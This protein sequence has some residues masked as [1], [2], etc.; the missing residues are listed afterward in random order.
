MGRQMDLD[1][2]TERELTDIEWADAWFE[3]RELLRGLKG[4][5]YTEVELWANDRR[6]RRLR[7]LNKRRRKLGLQPVPV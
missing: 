4:D 5:S 6:R 1:L 3:Y 2:E 7:A